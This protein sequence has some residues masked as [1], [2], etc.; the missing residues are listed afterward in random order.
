MNLLYA[1]QEQNIIIT[2]SEYYNT[3]SDFA[4]EHQLIV[5]GANALF[6]EQ[7]EKDKPAEERTYN[8]DGSFSLRFNYTGGIPKFVYYNNKQKTIFFR[9]IVGGEM[10]LVK[11]KLETIDWLITDETRT[12]SSFLCN[13]AI[14]KFRGRTYQ[15]WF[16]TAIP[17]NYGP[18]KLQ[19]LP[20]L[21]L[22]ATDNDGFYHVAATTFQFNDQK[23]MLHD[24]LLKDV[25]W[26]K[27][28]EFEKF[29]KLNKTSA[30]MSFKKLQAS[31][32]R[33][34][35][36]EMSDEKVPELELFDE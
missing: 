4:W 29:L 16:T 33:G 13:K 27:A 3:R 22:E 31:M 34:T 18:W 7:I 23:I 32:P 20:G 14:G 19:G 28:I 17:I 2:Y 24:E 15:A 10:V 36:L 30:E 9:K 11:D 5:E 26:E 12:I 35:K 8:E 21:V 1:Q 25:K 6:I